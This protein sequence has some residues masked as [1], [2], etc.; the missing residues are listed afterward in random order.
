MYIRPQNSRSRDRK[1]S[2]RVNMAMKLVSLPTETE[3]LVLE[4][5]DGDVLHLYVKL[6]E[7]CLNAIEKSVITSGVR[8]FFFVVEQV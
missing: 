6:T 7:S 2:K 8:I 1:L 5:D 4:E 3:H